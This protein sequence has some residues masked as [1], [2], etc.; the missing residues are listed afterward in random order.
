MIEAVERS[1]SSGGSS[2]DLLE[3]ERPHVA[4]MPTDEPLEV[5]GGA[6]LTS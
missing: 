2:I 5:V 1:I 6:R 3:Q 4:R